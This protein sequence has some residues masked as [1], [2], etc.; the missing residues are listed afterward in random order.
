M[1]KKSKARIVDKSKTQSG[2]AEKTDPN[3]VEFTYYFQRAGTPAKNSERTGE[4]RVT[5]TT[6][7]AAAQHLW[8]R[9]GRFA[10][11]IADCAALPDESG[12]EHPEPRHVQIPL[13]PREVGLVKKESGFPEQEPFAAILGCVDARAPVE[14]LFAQGFD[15]LYTIRMAGNTLGPDCAGSLHYALHSFGALKGKDEQELAKRT[16]RLVVALGHSDCGAVTTA[17]N[18]FL[19]PAALPGLEGKYLPDG[20][21]RGLLAKIQHP[22]VAAALEALPVGSLGTSPHSTKI[23]LAALIDISVHLNAAWCAHEIMTLVEQYDW[24]DSHRRVEVRYGV[25][26]PRDCYVRAGSE[27]YLFVEQGQVAPAPDQHSHA[28]APPPADL[29]ELRQLGTK[30]AEKITLRCAT[31]GGM[32]ALSRHYRVVLP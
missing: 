1:A 5:P 15:D 23:H 22:A 13:L 2:G 10:E 32:E 3:L 28:L 25:F 12:A 24:V 17:V 19:D 4:R 9:N 16:L 31:K 26:D 27:H 21:V 14:T 30:L 20:S 8:R 29:R 7:E 6:A 11:F 18:T